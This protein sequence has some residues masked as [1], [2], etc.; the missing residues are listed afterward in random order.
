[1][2]VSSSSPSAK[3]A[4][5]KQACSG[6]SAPCQGIVASASVRRSVAISARCP[7]LR[8]AVQQQGELVAAQAPD[9]IATAHGGGHGHGEQ[10][11]RRVAGGVAVGVVDRLEAVQIRQH[12]DARPAVTARVGQ[13]PAQVAQEAAA[14]E[15]AGQFVGHA[16]PLQLGNPCAL[17]GQHLLRLGDQHQGPFQQQAGRRGVGGIERHAGQPVKAPRQRLGRRRVGGARGEGERHRRNPSAT[18]FLARPLGSGGGVTGGQQ[19]ACQR[20][21][22]EWPGEID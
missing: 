4:T 8:G 21:P 7:G 1:M 18:S 19:T 6:I 2:S 5:P 14:V 15:Q 10:A 17:V 13:L 22:G 16:Q 11:D 12:Q 20:R 9:D 3:P